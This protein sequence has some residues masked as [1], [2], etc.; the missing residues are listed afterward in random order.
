MT[1]KKLREIGKK[2][3]AL[4]TDWDRLNFL[5]AN[6]TAVKAVLDND[7]TMVAFIEQPDID[8][9]DFDNLI[10]S[11]E[12]NDFDDYHYWSDGCLLLFKFAGITAES[13]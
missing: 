7:V 4:K 2:Y 8:E 5:K 1:L 3:N 11:F 9:D 10:E 6:N 13:C 12:L